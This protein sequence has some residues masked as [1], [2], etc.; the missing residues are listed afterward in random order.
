MARPWKLVHNTPDTII[1]Q[2]RDTDSI[3]VRL[4]KQPSGQWTGVSHFGN[5]HFPVPGWTIY[6]LGPFKSRTAAIHGAR[7]WMK[8][9]P[10][11]S[12]AERDRKAV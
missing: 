3:I 11:A 2:R 9:N 6:Y 12:Y 4:N 7:E 1:W 8:A 10:D 5:W